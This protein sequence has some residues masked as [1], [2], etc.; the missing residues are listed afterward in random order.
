MYILHAASATKDT[1]LKYS[2]VTSLRQQAQFSDAR[3]TTE[4]ESHVMAAAE[5]TH[6]ENTGN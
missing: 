3:T 6:F 4:D 1:E 5:K 2:D